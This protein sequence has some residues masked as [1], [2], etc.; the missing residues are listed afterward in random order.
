[1]RSR[2]KSKKDK[3]E[4]NLSFGGHRQKPIGTLNSARIGGDVK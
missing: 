4:H 3:N 2:K 1:V